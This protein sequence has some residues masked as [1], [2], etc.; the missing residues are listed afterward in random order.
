VRAGNLGFPRI[1]PRRE[2]KRALEAYWRGRSSA[3]ELREAAARIRSANWQLQ[4]RL[5]LY[6][7]PSNDFS[8]YDHV[9]DTAVMLGA[10][11]ERFLG[12]DGTVS[13]DAYFAMAR[14]GRLG[15]NSLAALEMTKWFDTNYHYLVPELT[16]GQRFRARPAKA[17]G[18]LKEAAAMGIA[19][20]PVLLGPVSF[21]W[22]AKCNW[23]CGDYQ[24]LL[25]S[26]VRGYQDVLA[27]LAGAGAGWV[28]VD[29]PALGLDL[30]SEVTGSY[31]NVYQ[32]LAEVA[33]GLQ[34]LV[35]TYFTGL[36]RNLPLALS[37]PVAALHLDV[38][39][40][41][42]Q[43]EPA[44][45]SVPDDLRLSLGVVSGRN[46]WRS[47]LETAL[48]LLEVAKDSIGADRLMVAPSCSLLHLP[49]DAEGESD[50]DP[51]VR[52]WL[53]FATQRLEEVAILT[54]ALNEG[55]PAVADVL[56]ESHTAAAGRP[57][58]PRAHNPAVRERVRASEAQELG[59]GPRELRKKA[60]AERLSL[61]VL[62]TTTVGSFP[63]TSEVRA[64]RARWRRGDLPDEG[65]R[66]AMRAYISGAVAFQDEIGLDVIV[67][68][69]P[70]RN[71][72]VEYFAEHLDGFAITEN[73]WVQSYGSRCVKPPVIYGDVSR[74]APITVEWARYAQSLTERPVKGMLTGPVTMMK[75]SFVRDDQPLSETCRQ[76]ALAVRDEVVD[77]EAAGLGI[78]QIDE[79]A[80][81]EGLP[82]HVEDWPRYLGWAVDAFRLAS[83]GA[84][85][86]TQVH[87]HMCYAEFDDIMDA[88]VALDADVIS[89]EAAR[90]GMQLLKSFTSVSYPNDIGP[91]IWDIHSPRTPTVEELDALLGELM[92][93]VP[94]DHL[95]VNPDCGLKTRSW[96]EVRPALRNMV[97]AARGRRRSLLDR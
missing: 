7:I 3:A 83:S 25:S 28:Q 14:G 97:V 87:T 39:A 24:E 49:V 77:L 30:P 57:R 10:V 45:E 91:G 78:I 43:L 50:V 71:D 8:L 33:P 64:L 13:L 52:R 58:S 75:W 32:E 35:A 70:E 68:G 53:A 29:E 6:D 20:R 61:P 76:I 69:E 15:G 80:L 21:L 41:P 42:E 94:V 86:H 92:E 19:T 88:I 67:H 89:I 44:L 66:A 96:E 81:R 9:L 37:L 26:L 59:R 31:R 27:A 22:L 74:P 65:Y 85:A 93:I 11:P 56:A 63:Q 84:G 38:V 46:V 95:W 23:R 62:P 16:T 4:H 47:D 54:R 40:G 2:L 55:R 90:S 82:L 18:E 73:G 17:L 36:R 1:G 60:Q 5:G 79:P 48:R 12:S 51:D 72:M 34:I